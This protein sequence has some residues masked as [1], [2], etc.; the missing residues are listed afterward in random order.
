MINYSKLGKKILL[1]D[2]IKQEKHKT[3]KKKIKKLTFRTG[4]FLSNSLTT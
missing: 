4:T 1:K 2:Q 3:L